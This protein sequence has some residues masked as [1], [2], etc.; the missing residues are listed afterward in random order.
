M[1]VK[2]STWFHVTIILIVIVIWKFAITTEYFGSRNRKLTEA[3]GGFRDADE[4][5]RLRSGALY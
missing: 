3:S 1:E 4:P 2:N 5:L